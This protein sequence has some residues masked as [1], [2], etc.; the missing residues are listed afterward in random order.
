[1]LCIRFS[2]ESARSPSMYEN[3]FPLFS[4]GSERCRCPMLRMIQ[5]YVTRQW[6]VTHYLRSKSRIP[7]W[8]A[9]GN[10]R[11]SRRARAAARQFH[12]IYAARARSY[13]LARIATLP[14]GDDDPRR[15][16]SFNIYPARSPVRAD[17]APLNRVAALII[18]VRLNGR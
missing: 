1:M 2:I 5:H 18:V 12:S 3:L 4:D 13:C 7:A 9:R 14:T 15:R 17:N 6:A 8:G 10:R 16:F 11:Q